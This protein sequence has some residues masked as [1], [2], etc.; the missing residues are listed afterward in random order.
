[1]INSAP[2]LLVTMEALNV[3]ESARVRVELLSWPNHRA[4]YG[5]AKNEG[6]VRRAHFGLY[7]WNRDKRSV[8]FAT[9]EN[10][11][12]KRILLVV[13]NI[14]QYEDPSH[15]IGLWLSELTHAWHVFKDHGFE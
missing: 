4:C 15:P 6:L 9:R 11:M 7:I 1:M 2:V 12:P 14:K 13:T 3:P 8:G 10:I 5:H